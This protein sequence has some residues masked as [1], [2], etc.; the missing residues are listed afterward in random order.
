MFEIPP[1]LNCECKSSH[2]LV[3]EISASRERF[4]QPRHKTERSE[5]AARVRGKVI[6]LDIR[7]EHL[8]RH[9]GIFERADGNAG[10]LCLGG[11]LQADPGTSQDRRPACIDC[12]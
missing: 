10:T 9:Q 11:G 2:D 4:W 6:I 7:L 8:K 5:I 12:D 1:R 3:A